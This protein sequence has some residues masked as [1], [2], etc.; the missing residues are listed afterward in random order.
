MA[1]AYPLAGANVLLRDATPKFKLGTPL[2]DDSNQTWVYV[3]AGA[4]HAADARV[5]L[6]NFVTSADSEAGAYVA[7][8]AITKDEYGW[9]KKYTAA[10]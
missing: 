7:A 6:T 5:A 1:G 4:S 3:Q 8:T 2:I 10:L 9:V